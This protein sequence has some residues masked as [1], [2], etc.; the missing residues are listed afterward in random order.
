MS[1]TPRVIGHRGFRLMFPENTLLAFNEAIKS[2]STLIETDV[3][4]SK[5]GVIVISHDH[6]TNRSFG[7]PLI[8]Q[9]V[10]YAESLL[11]LKTVAEPRESILTFARLLQWAIKKHED[12]VP[13]KFMLDI[14]P[15]NNPKIVSVILENL[16]KTGKSLDYW[17]DKIIFGF[18]TEPYLRYAHEHH[19]EDL[20]LFE[21]LIISVSPAIVAD[22][23][24]VV[25]TLP[26]VGRTKF[27][28]DSVS[29]LFISTCGPQFPGYFR[30][31]KRRGINLYTWT[32]NAAEDASWSCRLG[33]SGIITDNVDAIRDAVQSGK[34]REPVQDNVLEPYLFPSLLTSQ[35]VRKYGRFCTFKVFESIKYYNLSGVGVGPYNIGAAIHGVSRAFGVI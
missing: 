10:N 5:D 19:A 27:K 6:Q 25:D 32:V 20:A 21:K 11:A 23:L 2:G 33:V 1:S 17:H 28:I 8:I 22:L 14:K 29:L 24:E 7:E 30:E 35:G 13:V 26:M 31:Y 4:M 3:Q 12:N 15:V 9:D 16:A 18:W 34:M